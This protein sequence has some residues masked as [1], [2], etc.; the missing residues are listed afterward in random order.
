MDACPE[1]RIQ[2]VLKECDEKR[3]EPNSRPIKLMNWRQ[4]VTMTMESID[5]SVAGSPRP[6]TITVPLYRPASFATVSFV[7]GA[8]GLSCREPGLTARRRGAPT[9]R[10]RLRTAA[11]DLRVENPQPAF[12]ET[13]GLRH[14]VDR[15]FFFFFFFFG[16]WNSFDLATHHRSGSFQSSA[17]LSCNFPALKSISRTQPNPNFI[18]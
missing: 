13:C 10:S 2:R 18:W 5:S 16:I 7:A 6:V 4:R 14:A 17:A 9:S 15:G 8:A 3:C 11:R 12:W 1:Q